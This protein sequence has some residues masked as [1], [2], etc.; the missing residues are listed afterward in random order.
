MRDRAATPQ[1][2]R[3][4][5]PLLPSK[6]SRATSACIRI[7]SVPGHAPGMR[8]P[9][10]ARVSGANHGSRPKMGGNGRRGG[11]KIEHA[12][13]MFA[14]RF[15]MTARRALQRRDETRFA[16][17]PCHAE[18]ARIAEP[19]DCTAIRT[20]FHRFDAERRAPREKSQHAG[21]IVGF[22]VGQLDAGRFILWQF[23][24]VRKQ[25]GSGDQDANVHRIAQRDSDAESPQANRAP[26]TQIFRANGFERRRHPM[27]FFRR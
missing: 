18:R 7:G 8:N 27:L 3:A 22:D 13:Q 15:R 10:T 26:S 14:N 21:P 20:V 6:G 12:R 2:G 24:R 25:G 9:G 11:L 4:G 19:L 16:G 23:R 1:R 5:P 17:V